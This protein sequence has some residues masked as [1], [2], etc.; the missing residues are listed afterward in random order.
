M[1]IRTRDLKAAE[2]S[3]PE[4]F[5]QWDKAYDDYH[6]TYMKD[7]KMHEQKKHGAGEDAYLEYMMQKR[8]DWG[9]HYKLMF[10]EHYV[11]TMKNYIRY[12]FVSYA[13]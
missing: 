1:K 6:G 13:F 7:G 11:P 8:E 5:F 2:I 9:T 4:A 10:N 12:F 3:T